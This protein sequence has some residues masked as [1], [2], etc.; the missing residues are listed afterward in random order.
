M[1]DITFS[2]PLLPS[3]KTVQGIAGDTHTLLAVARE[4]G[5]A[6]PFSCEVG[7]CCSCLI[8]VTVLEDKTPMS[9]TLSEKEKFTLA[10]HGKLSK[11]AQEMA[12]VADIPPHYRLACQYVVRHENILVEFSGKAGLE[13]DPSRPKHERATTADVETTGAEDKSYEE[14]STGQKRA[15]HHDSTGSQDDGSV[16]HL[17]IDVAHHSEPK[18]GG[19]EASHLGGMINDGQVK[20]RVDP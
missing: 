3:N 15:V 1:A 5:I 14:F 7:D 2:S 12:E 11:E 8:K 16:N 6:I 19:D 9:G 17:A 13:I 10:A 18:I 4:N 20:R